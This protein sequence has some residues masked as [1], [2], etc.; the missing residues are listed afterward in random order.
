MAARKKAVK[1]VANFDDQDAV[2]DEVA[3]KIDYDPADL[4]IDT[5][6]GLESFGTGTVYNISA[7]RTEWQVVESADQMRELAIAVVTQ[8]LE[9]E[10]EIFNKDFIEQHINTDRLKR[11]LL[12]D[13][14]QSQY[15]NLRDM[16]ADDFWKEWERSGRDAPEED[17]DGDRREPDDNEIV[18]LA[19]EQ[20]EELLQD[21]MRYLEDIYG[22]EAAA[23]AIEIAGIDIEA[24]AEEAVDTDGPEHFLAR[25]DGHSYETPSG[26]V[27]WRSN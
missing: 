13:V 6:S 7:G 20:A 22:D 24:A 2:L 21:P 14:E 4:V 3:K 5:D 12:S 23:K 26:F 11:D 15:D 16:D 18:E 19:D 9:Q 8:D 17:E 25:Y 27:Y 1:R 10:P